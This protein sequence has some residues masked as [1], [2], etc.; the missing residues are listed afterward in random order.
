MSITPI[1]PAGS[2]PRPTIAVTMGDPI[3][4]GPELVVKV[5]SDARL[6][7]RARFVIYGVAEPMHYAADL[8]EIDPYWRRV[9]HD[10][11]LVDTAIGAG[12]TVRDYDEYSL[13]GP[14]GDRRHT[15]GPSRLGGHSSFRFV[16]DA[17]FD[18]CRE[19]GDPLRIDGL[20][21]APICKQSW[22]MA[23]RGKYAGHTELL[24][25][26]FGAKRI[27]MAFFSPKLRVVLVTRHVPLMDLR[28]IL[29]IGRIFDPIDL[30]ND[31]L[32]ELGVARPRIAVCGVNPHAGEGGLF[33]DEETR[34]IEPAIRALN[35][36]GID[37]CG[38]YSADTVFHRALAGEFDLV[39]AM[40]HDQGLIP[41]KL[42][43][44]RDAVNVTLGLPIVRTSPDH[45]TAFDIAGKN[46]ADESSMRAA[47][48]M[49]IDLCLSRRAMVDAAAGQS[50]ITTR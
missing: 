14:T 46:Q 41:V 7:R 38:P 27:A 28:N 34:L 33:G 9:Q 40:Y 17:I 22:A 26:R 37:A 25:A 2:E 1:H 47:V 5:F 32:R 39:A 15:V 49:A 11:K 4:I 30:A 50:A 16:E 35:E 42:L 13:A 21:T 20:V 43:A 45:G 23:G 10:S 31:A 36:A 8:A 6:R 44:W 12:V 3:G 29:T 18:A 48:E 19:A 24:G